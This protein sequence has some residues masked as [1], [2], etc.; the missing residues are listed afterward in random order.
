MGN[1]IE[2]KNLRESKRTNLSEVIPLPA[3][4]VM[5]IE[6]TNLCNFRCAFCPTSDKQ[7]LKRVGRPSGMMDIKL[8]K[9]IVD[10]TKDL[11]TKINVIHLYKDG[12]PLLHPKFPEMIHYVKECGITSKICV[13]TNGSLLNPELN[14]RIVDSGLNWLGISIEAVSSDGYKKI[15]G[16]SLDYEKFK[17]NVSDLFSR[18]KD[19]QIYIKIVDNHLTVEE[20]QKF[21]DDF[22]RICD[23]YAIENLMGWSYSSVKDFTLGTHPATSVE[24]IPFSER[25]VC[26]FPFYSLAINFNGSASICCSDWSHSTIVGN[27]GENSIKEIWNGEKLYNFQKMHL[28]GN[29][30]QNRA[31]GDCYYIK[32][33][34][35]NIDKDK[36]IILKNI[37]SS[38]ARK[39]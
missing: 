27:A 32:M 39:K 20:K 15:S 30:C 29:R 2:A 35:D 11:H 5:Y 28:L 34:P 36:E 7:L 38:F 3:P 16:V 24:G 14:Q 9:K 22:S 33:L 1:S 18:K 23:N 26:P 17:E 8:F 4:Y 12:E 37:E 25:E 31:C 13:K 19:M 10:E 21:S 6:P